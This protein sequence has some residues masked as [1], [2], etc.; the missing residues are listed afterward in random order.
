MTDAVAASQTATT[1]GR[2]FD[3]GKLRYGLL[4]PYALEEN[5]KVLTFG[6]EKYEPD[7]WKHV[8]DGPRRYF[9]AAQRH[10][11]AYKRGEMY[12]PETG[13]HHLAHALCCLEFIIDCDLDPGIDRAK[14]ISVYK[15]GQIDPSNLKAI[16]AG[17][18]ESP[19]LSTAGGQLLCTSA[20]N[21]ITTGFSGEL[22]G[23]TALFGTAI[24]PSGVWQCHDMANPE[25]KK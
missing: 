13:I 19:R 10:M 24:G 18:E 1:G 3:G 6:A 16:A 15:G 21:F 22:T 8:P 14:K 5:V 12:D 2:K 9:D 17:R 11:W 20:E 7:N 25:Y 23:P 4:P